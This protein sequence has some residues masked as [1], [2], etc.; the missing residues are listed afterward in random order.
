MRTS[1]QRGGSVVLPATSMTSNDFL[2]LQLSGWPET[3][4][5]NSVEVLTCPKK[6]S[7]CAILQ[8]VTIKV[9]L[10]PLSISDCCVEA[11]LTK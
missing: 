1:W 4:C 6:L 9:Q 2:I 8:D 10:V 7:T 5:P 11:F 3:D